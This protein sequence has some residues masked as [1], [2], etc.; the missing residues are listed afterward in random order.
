MQPNQVVSTPASAVHFHER[1][2]LRNKAWARSWENATILRIFFLCF[3]LISNDLN[4]LI[5]R[6]LTA[7]FGYRGQPLSASLRSW[8]PWHRE[9]RRQTCSEN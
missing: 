1:Y 4:C 5:L 7:L 6:K 9:A 2:T 3:E 8:A